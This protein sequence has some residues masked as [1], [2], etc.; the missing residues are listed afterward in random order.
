MGGGY[1]Q[2]GGTGGQVIITLAL[3]FLNAL[4]ESKL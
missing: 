1:G 4:L 3:S 2:Q